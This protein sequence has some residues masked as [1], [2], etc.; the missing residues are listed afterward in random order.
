MDED[1]FRDAYYSA[2]PTACAFEKALLSQTCQCRHSSRVCV[3]DRQGVACD[4]ARDRECC[5]AFLQR[6]RRDGR[7]ALHLS[8]VPARLPHAQEIRVQMGSVR[9]LCELLGVADAVPDVSELLKAA[10][11]R[12]DRLDRIPLQSIVAAVGAVQSR[13]RRR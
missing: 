4:D 7:F 11:A 3:A 10:L 2:N 1:L 9:G 13:Q 8:Q 12:Y 5:A 6:V